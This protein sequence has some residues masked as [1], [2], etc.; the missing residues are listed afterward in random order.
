MPSAAHCHP[1][2][3]SFNAGLVDACAN[4]ALALALALA[5]AVHDVPVLVEL[6]DATTVVDDA[7]AT[8]SP[9]PVLLSDPDN[10]DELE[11]AS[12]LSLTT[13]LEY[14]PVRSPYE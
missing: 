2:T 8:L 5:L 3:R 6:A 1:S 12:S 11:F 13:M 14:A 7:F 4:V 9:A 10:A